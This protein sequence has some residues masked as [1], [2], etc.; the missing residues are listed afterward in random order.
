MSRYPA[1]TY[2]DVVFVVKKLGF[3]L[4][5]HKSTSHMQYK[6]PV[7]GKKVTISKHNKKNFGPDLITW[8]V[9]QIGI[10]KKEFFTLL[11]Q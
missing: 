4:K 3:E 5:S 1:I 10:T 7:S 6:H 11:E 2:K 8:T 9:R